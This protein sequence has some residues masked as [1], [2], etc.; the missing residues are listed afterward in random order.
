MRQTLAYLDLGHLV[1]PLLHTDSGFGTLQ[2][3]QCIVIS[4][5][6][7]D[8]EV[9]ASKSCTVAY[10]PT[11]HSDAVVTVSYSRLKIEVC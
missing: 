1:L 11:A 6:Q 10:L 2:Q 9:S 3:I 8:T 5:L 4:D 7:S